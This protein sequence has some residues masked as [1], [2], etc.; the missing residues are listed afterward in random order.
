MKSERNLYSTTIHV[1][2]SAI[3]K[4]S[5]LTKIES[6]VRLYRGLGGELQYPE[7]FFKRD[8]L[9]CRGMLEW[10]FVS[11]TSKK[12]DAIQYSGVAEKKPIPTVLEIRPG[13][14]DRGACIEKFSQYPR[15]AE[16]VWA[17]FVYFE[18]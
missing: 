18:P 7:S 17:P 8:C 4:L 3:L 11:T 6:N 14:L 2:T 5:R 9:G 13:A 10:S 16:Y 12:D 1:L 15:E